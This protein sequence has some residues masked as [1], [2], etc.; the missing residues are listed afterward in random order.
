M[1]N[2]LTARPEDRVETESPKDQPLPLTTQEDPAAVED[3]PPP[4]SPTA[5]NNPRQTASPE[6]K[7]YVDADEE[8]T[9]PEEHSLDPYDLLRDDPFALVPQ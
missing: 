7:T 4:T 2:D 3:A 5:E 1:E 9:E 6:E 8:V